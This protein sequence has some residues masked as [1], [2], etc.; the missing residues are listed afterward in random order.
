MDKRTPTDE[1]IAALLLLRA[2]GG[3]ARAGQLS[4]QALERTKKGFDGR[5]VRSAPRNRAVAPGL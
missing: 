5:E 2:R 4:L 1:T 3:H